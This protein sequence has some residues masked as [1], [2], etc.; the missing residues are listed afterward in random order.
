M[1]AVISFLRW[2][3][4]NRRVAHVMAAFLLL[5]LALNPI[6]MALNGG[7][8]LGL[9]SNFD[10]KRPSSTVHAHIGQIMQR[11]I[12]AS[13]LQPERPLSDILREHV[14]CSERCPVFHPNISK[15]AASAEETASRAQ[16]SRVAQSAELRQVSL[17]MW[18]AKRMDVAAARV[19][20][21]AVL[22]SHAM[23]SS[24]YD[25]SQEFSDTN[26]ICRSHQ[27][28]NLLL[29][30]VTHEYRGRSINRTSLLLD[31]HN[32]EWYTSFGYNPLNVTDSRLA[33]D[34]PDFTHEDW[35]QFCLV[36]VGRQS[37]T[38]TVPAHFVA[39]RSRAWHACAAFAAST[40]ARHYHHGMGRCFDVPPSVL[41]ADAGQLTELLHS[42][43]S[44]LEYIAQC[45]SNRTHILDDPWSLRNLSSSVFQVLRDRWDAVQSVYELAV[46]ESNRDIQRSDEFAEAL[47]WNTCHPHVQALHLMIES[48]ASKSHFDHITS[49][50][51]SF[52]DPCKKLRGVP[53]MKRMHYKDALVYA[54]SF[55]GSVFM[56]SN[57]DAVVGGGFDSVPS[58]HSF[59][60]EEDGEKQRFLALS[61]LERP[62]S[63]RN[64]TRCSTFAIGWF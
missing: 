56:I 1:I 53:L 21:C 48:N 32:T 54:N 25:G 44:H 55:A 4:K 63:V 62:P 49:H 52:H 34:A 43:G 2:S 26:G 5:F 36:Q 9:M 29:P 50:S 39:P 58:L 15:F 14:V 30:L 11:I 37:K 38:P 23:F 51:N 16:W 35:L 45:K 28:I 31:P 6:H 41:A 18:A 12:S 20:G 40:R 61:R 10:T 7:S 60:R 3:L 27:Q 19:L 64:P 33:Y 59:L 13:Q 8:S 22:R 57:A 47:Q 24:S 46:Y 42:Y 17:Q